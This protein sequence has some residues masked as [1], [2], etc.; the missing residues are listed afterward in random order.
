MYMCSIQVIV[1]VR[2]Y[3]YTVHVLQVLSKWHKVHNFILCTAFF[4]NGI[5]VHV[6]LNSFT[7]VESVQIHVYTCIFEGA[8]YLECFTLKR[9]EG[10]REGEG[11]E[12]E[13]ER[14]RRGKERGKD[15]RG[16]RGEGR[17]ER[18]RN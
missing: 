16:R 18:R 7:S 12:R 15:G 10:G 13:G 4:L 17:R 1:H 9:R 5:H 2:I 3:M 8:D 6:Y 14:E 11:K